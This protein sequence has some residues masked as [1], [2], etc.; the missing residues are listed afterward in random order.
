VT[1]ER[2]GITA[3]K[4]APIA[5]TGSV[6]VGRTRTTVQ[7]IVTITGIVV[8]DGVSGTKLSTT[9]LKIANRTSIAGT[10]GAKE[11]KIYTNALRIVGIAGT[12]TVLG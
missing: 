11:E 10:D 3:W 9:A 1:K 5:G 4:I 8:M 2:T 6:R 7:R 12:D